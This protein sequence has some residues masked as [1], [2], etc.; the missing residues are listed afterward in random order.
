MYIMVSS[1]P[2]KVYFAYADHSLTDYVQIIHIKFVATA[3]I[4]RVSIRGAKGICK[5]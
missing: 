4:R 5:Y 2:F 1:C 3:G